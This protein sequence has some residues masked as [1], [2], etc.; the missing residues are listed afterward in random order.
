MYQKSKMTQKASTCRDT[1]LIDRKGHLYII[2]VLTCLSQ[3]TTLLTPVVTSAGTSK[4]EV[5][6]RSVHLDLRAACAAKPAIVLTQ[7]VTWLARRDH[8][9]I[10]RSSAQQ[11][12][13]IPI[14]QALL[15][16]RKISWVR[17]EKA[18][19]IYRI[20]GQADAQL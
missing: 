2:W 5:S 11:R 13:Q 15:V 16:Y 3:P 4:D 14:L 7:S 19:T 12:F 1:N 10:Q 9:H 6:T 17:E 18:N 8:A 20:L